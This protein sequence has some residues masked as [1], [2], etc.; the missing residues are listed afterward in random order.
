MLYADWTHGLTSR[1]KTNRNSHPFRQ[2]A[3]TLVSMIAI[4]DVNKRPAAMLKQISPSPDAYAG[5][6]KG[7]ALRRAWGRS[8]TKTV[9]MLGNR[10]ARIVGVT[11][12]AKGTGVSSFAGALA[13][14]YA[15]LSHRVLVLDASRLPK[16]ASEA[17]RDTDKAASGLDVTS[18]IQ[19]IDSV[20]LLDLAAVPMLSGA[21][22]ETIRKG[23]AM[24]AEKFDMV[25]IDLPAATRDANGTVARGFAA[26]AACD[27][28][29]MVC[30]TGQPTNMDLTDSL[31]LCSIQKL[32][33]AGLILNDWKLQFGT[34][35]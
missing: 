31:Q 28:I 10:P 6:A 17:A 21:T 15:S 16:S 1:A 4:A 34:W 33:I 30:V 14:T 9:A 25:I 29:L 8:T 22:D 26:G 12:H 18:L 3:T 7:A 11:S 5:W 32:P 19:R 2:R 13:E 23:V 24:L 27:S 35:L 20:S